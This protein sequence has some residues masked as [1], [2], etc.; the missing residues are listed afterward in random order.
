MKLSVLMSVYSRERKE[1]LRESLASLVS[2]TRPADEVILVEDGPLGEDL[3]EVIASF[4]LALPIVSLK[5]ASNVGLGTALQIGL[6]AC[7]GEYVARM[8]SDDVCGP[9][10]F[11]KQMA[12]LIEH[13]EVDVLGSAI[14]EFRHDCSDAYS[15]RRLPAAGQ[16][17]LKFAKRRNP[18]NHMTAVFRKASV[19]EI[20]GYKAFNG[21]EDYHLWARMLKA[22]YCLEN[23]RDVLVYVRCGNG[24]QQ[25]RGGL[26]YLKRE[27]IFLSSLHREGF[28][29]AFEC[30]SSILFRIP[31]RLLPSSV[32]SLFYN[33]LL[34]HR[35]A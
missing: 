29:T 5:L 35:P 4:R 33:R 32:R 30:F 31:I 27:T 9:D 7:S 2:Q 23:M 18:M 6:E 25:R 22:G 21:F 11:L 8:D 12:Y 20:G 10:R 24:M 3:L 14:A 26:D 17:M 28:L 19:I 1:F 15:I 16:S 13:P 34:R